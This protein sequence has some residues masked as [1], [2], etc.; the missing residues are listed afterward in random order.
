MATKTSQRRTAERRRQ[1]IASTLRYPT[2]DAKAVDLFA[3]TFHLLNAPRPEVQVF[4]Y[5]Q[6]VA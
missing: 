2:T 3:Q 4:V 1:Q 6:E 5:G